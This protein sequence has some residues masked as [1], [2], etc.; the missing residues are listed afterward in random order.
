MKTIY[1]EKVDKP[2]MAIQ[3]IKIE[4]DCCKIRLNLEF[5]GV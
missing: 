3:K 4:R 1:I 2:K 5:E